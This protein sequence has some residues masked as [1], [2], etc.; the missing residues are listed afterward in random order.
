MTPVERASSTRLACQLGRLVEPPAAREHV[1]AQAVRA[2][3][4]VEASSQHGVTVGVVEHAEDRIVR[5]AFK[6]PDEPEALL[7]RSS[8]RFA[9]SQRFGGLGARQRCVV[10]S[11]EQP[12]DRRE[13][14]LHVGEACPLVVGV[15]SRGDLL[16]EARSLDQLPRKLS[17]SRQPVD[18]IEAAADVVVRPELEGMPVCLRGLS[19]RVDDTRPLGGGD[20]GVSRQV[21]LA[22]GEPVLG[23]HARRSAAALEALR[24]ATMELLP[25][26][27]GRVRVD[28]LS[29]QCVS[30]G[31]GPGLGLDDEPERDGLGQVDVARKRFDELEIEAQTDDRGELQARA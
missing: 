3:R 31:C 28:R 11:P 15:Q 16:P 7:R 20:E 30:K 25:T 14:S 13:L 21:E 23:E 26:R 24:D 4:E 19:V 8:E 1:G 12:V 29:G 2:G 9:G 10:T 18:H 17:A 22:A 6:I 27:P 5:V